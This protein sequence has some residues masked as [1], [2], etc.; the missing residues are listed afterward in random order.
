VIWIM[1]V[2]QPILKFNKYSV[3]EY[4]QIISKHQS[5]NFMSPV[6]FNLCT[7]WLYKVG[8]SEIY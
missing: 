1:V 4:I 6:V 7:E 8:N 3:Y 2:H 5:N